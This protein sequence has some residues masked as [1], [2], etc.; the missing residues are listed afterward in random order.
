MK[1]FEA[2][3]LFQCFWLPGS[4][5]VAVESSAAFCPE[6]HLHIPA[7]GA[8]SHKGGLC[9]SSHISSSL[10]HLGF[11]RIQGFLL[12]YHCL[13]VGFLLCLVFKHCQ[14]LLFHWLLT[15]QYK[16]VLVQIGIWGCCTIWNVFTLKHVVASWDQFPFGLW[17]K[18]IQD[19]PYGKVTFKESP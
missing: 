18:K 5:L 15:F 2:Q 17:S 12:C 16:M 1:S 19:E 14:T 13:C 11:L 9:A 3:N 8:P 10:M 4:F 7:K 6:L